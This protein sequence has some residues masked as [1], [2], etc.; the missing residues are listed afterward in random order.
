LEAGP[1][2]TYYPDEAYSDKKVALAAAKKE[3]KSATNSIF[4]ETN[5]VPDVNRLL[6]KIKPYVNRIVDSYVLSY[7]VAC[8]KR[9]NLV[10]AVA[11]IREWSDKKDEEPC[12]S[13]DN[14]KGNMWSSRE[15][16]LYTNENI[17]FKDW[18]KVDNVESVMYHDAENTQPQ[19][20]RFVVGK[21]KLRRSKIVKSYNELSIA[22]NS[23]VK[24]VSGITQSSGDVTKIL[25]EVESYGFAVKTME[26]VLASFPKDM[27]NNLFNLTDERKN[28]TA[29]ISDEEKEKMKHILSRKIAIAIIEA[30]GF[31]DDN[32]KKVNG[33][34][35]AKPTTNEDLA[36][37][38]KWANYVV[39]IYTLPKIGTDP[40]SILGDAVKSVTD[41]IDNITSIVKCK[42][43]FDAWGEAKNGQIL[44]SSG[45]GTFELTDHIHKYTNLRSEGNVME[46]DN[47]DYRGVGEKLISIRQTLSTL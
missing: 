6:G 34:L 38:D 44:F 46:E 47:P 18:V 13:Y 28:L 29:L 39:S 42:S 20:I 11:A 25:G 26:K 2:K 41:A 16:V 14:V 12:N 33:V 36:D 30:L 17:G 19:V 9:Q 37:T 43:Q 27:L 7:N 10:H 8:M 24:I 31:K 1:G 45:K 21:R 22:I 35:P 15:P 40:G 23:L 4:F 3:R 32:R 5:L